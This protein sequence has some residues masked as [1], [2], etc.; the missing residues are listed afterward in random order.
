MTYKIDDWPFQN[1]VL[2]H[3]EWHDML[4]DHPE[5][6][7]PMMYDL[8]LDG[9][10]LDALELHG[11]ILDCRPAYVSTDLCLTVVEY[12]VQYILS[13]FSSLTWHQT[14]RT[15]PQSFA[16]ILH[17]VYGFNIEEPTAN[18]VLVNIND[19]QDIFPGPTV[20]FAI[21]MFDRDS[22]YRKLI[23]ETRYFAEKNGEVVLEFVSGE[24]GRFDENLQFFGD[25]KFFGSE[26]A[27]GWIVRG[28]N[29]SD[30]KDI[31]IVLPDPGYEIDGWYLENGTRLE[32]NTRIE[33]NHRVTARFRK[34]QE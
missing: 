3:A 12:L 25:C 13:A 22:L 26:R 15:N 32:D 34:A 24:N 20:L 5:L 1:S 6:E 19:I 18:A 2:N 21:K 27:A 23:D 30:A 33:G 31:P 8:V 29:W 11:S 14:V 7:D 16:R 4:L 10:M 9:P 17:E 28:A